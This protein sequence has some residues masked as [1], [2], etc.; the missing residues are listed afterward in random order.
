MPPIALV[1]LLNP[2][3]ISGQQTQADMRAGLVDLRPQIDRLASFARSAPR[4]TVDIQ[5]KLVDVLQYLQQRTNINPVSQAYH[6]NRN[7]PSQRS[8]SPP[9]QCE[10]DV[11]L[12][13]KTVLSKLYR[14][15]LN[16]I[17]E[18][19]E[20]GAAKPV[21]HLFRLNPDDWQP[22]EL[23][24]AY[25]KGSPGGQ[26]LPHRPVF[27]PL[28]VDSSGNEVPCMEVHSTCTL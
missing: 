8:P 17:E 11:Q 12:T 10:H 28:L 20:T 24:I 27:I 13:V 26:T 1:D 18:Y 3:D 9:I 5:E 16:V 6:G 22:P 21:G 19:P 15:P 25:S 14:Y 4:G 2:S 23:N 7:P